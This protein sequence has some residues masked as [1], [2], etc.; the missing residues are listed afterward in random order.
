[1]V[2]ESKQGGGRRKE[3]HAEDKTASLLYTLNWCRT[4]PVQEQKYISIKLSI[5]QR[6]L[7]VLLHVEM[8]FVIS[9]KKW[10]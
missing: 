6:S 2:N 10:R 5:T 8:Q 1:M 3:L 9:S 7:F 4:L